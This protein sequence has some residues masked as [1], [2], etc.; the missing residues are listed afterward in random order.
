[1]LPARRW[2]RLPE[3]TADDTASEHQRHLLKPEAHTAWVVYVSLLEVEGATFPNA[4]KR[5]AFKRLGASTRERS[6]HG[7]VELHVLL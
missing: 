7:G 5:G 2:R 1:M 6:T 4:L 3:N